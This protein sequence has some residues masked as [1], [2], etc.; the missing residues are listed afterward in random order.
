MTDHITLKV[1]RFFSANTGSCGEK[2][3]GPAF[4]IDVEIYL[5]CSRPGESD[6]LC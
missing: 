5:P 6:D 2:S 1:M 4:V 3:A